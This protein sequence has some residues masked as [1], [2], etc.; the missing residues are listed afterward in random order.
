MYSIKKLNENGMTLLDTMIVAGILLVMIT[1]FASYQFQRN[2]ANQFNNSSNV[3]KQI[4]SN[5]KASA[6]DSQSL[7][8]SEELGFN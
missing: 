8:K 4:Q 6:S 5:V 3:F 1:A 2:K 7:Q